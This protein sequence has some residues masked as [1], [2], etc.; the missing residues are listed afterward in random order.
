[1]M[2][3]AQWTRI[4]EMDYDL[5]T[6]AARDVLAGRRNELDAIAGSVV[7]AGERLGVPS[8]VFRGSSPKP[9]GCDPGPRLRPRVA[10]VPA[11][12][13]SERVPQK[14]VRP[15]AGHPLLAYAIETALQSGVF[16]RVVVS[17]DSEDIAA[18][19]RWYGAEV[20]FL[21]PPVRDRNLAR[22]RVAHLHAR[23]TRR[24]VRPSPSF[25]RPTLPR[26]WRGSARPGAAPRH[27]GGG[28]ATRRRA[29]A[30]HPGRCGCRQGREDDVAAPRPVAPRRC[31]ARGSTR[32]C[33]RSARRTAR[34]RSRG[35]G[36]CRTSNA[37]GRIVAPFLTE[38][39]EGFN[40][41]D[42]G[43][44]ERAERLLESGVAQVPVIGREPYAPAS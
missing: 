5:T 43:D 35:P 2:P 36:S 16:D 38:G 27:A 29:F 9:T 14:N 3:S 24:V 11:R 41:D 34:S 8:P 17:T 7:R 18:I 23:E 42:E 10:F 33:P 20:P 22:H 30:A 6:S 19:A 26:A 40:V 21:R 4:M 37:R 31:L 44:W 28:L 15:L 12:A 1:M 25:A 39:H 32:R 13:G